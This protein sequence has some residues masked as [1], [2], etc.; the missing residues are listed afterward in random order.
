MVVFKIKLFNN[1][2]IK[3]TLKKINL[4]IFYSIFERFT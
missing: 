4:I 2:R 1:T 3:F